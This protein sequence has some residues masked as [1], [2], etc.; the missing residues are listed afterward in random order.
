MTDF[1][2]SY[3]QL[4]IMRAVHKHFWI[5]CLNSHYVWD[6]KDCWVCERWNS[7]E[8]KCSNIRIAALQQTNGL[9]ECVLYQMAIGGRASKYRYFPAS[10]CLCS[11]VSLLNSVSPPPNHRFRL[12]WVWIY[13]QI[14]LLWPRESFRVYWKPLKPSEWNIFSFR[15][16]LRVFN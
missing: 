11:R 8:F 14:Q 13:S 2:S 10:R 6:P 1:S 9:S 3:V 4:V 16:T 5:A 7:R 15:T 12:G